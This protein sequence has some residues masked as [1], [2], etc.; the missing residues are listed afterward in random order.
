MAPIRF[1]FGLHLH[2]PVGNFDHV[3]QQHVHDVYRPILER[4][5]E[6]GFLP[7]VL[8]LSG[9]LLEWLEEHDTGY[10]DLLG[11]LVS[12]RKVELLLAGFYEPVLASLPRADRVEQIQWMRDAVRRRFGVEGRGLWLTER[13]WEPELAADL[14]DAGVRYALVD[15]RHFLVS[16]FGSEQLHAPYWTESDGKRVALFPIDERLRYLIPFRPPEETASYL[17]GLR[18]AGHRLA[19]LADDGEKFGGWPGTREWVYERGWLDRFTGTIGGLVQAGEVQLSTLSDA[20]DTVPSAGIAYLPTASYREMEGWSLPPDAALRLI[21]LERE[22]GE[23]RMAGPDGALI[24]GAHWRNF[25][26]K[27]SESNRMHK[28]MQALSLL[29][30]QRGDPPSARRAIGRAQCNDAYWHGVFGGLYLPHLRE[31]IWRNLA[32]AEAELRRGEAV[33]VE[34]LDLDGDGHDE[35]WIHSDQFSAWLSPRRGGALEE[36][37]VFATGINYANALTRRREAYHDTA[38][39]QEAEAHAAAEGGAPSIHDIEEG[40]RLEHRPYVDAEPRAIF[41]ERVLPGDLTIEQYVSGDYRAVRSWA[42]SPCSFTIDR[43]HDSATIVC[44]FGAEAPLEKR[45][46]FA[47][48]GSLAVAYRWDPSIG[49]PEDFF[50]PELSLFAPLEVR[51]EPVAEVWSFPIETVAKSERGL[52]RTRQGDSMTLRWP[53]RRGHATVQMSWRLEPAMTSASE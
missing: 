52:D 20:L 51:S 32:L 9:P 50:A 53:V 12:D 28:K 8:H 37:T 22:L 17:R 21:R 15:D 23:E 2:Q 41:L 4:L 34:V 26:V 19:V 44:S 24:R 13:V 1:V 30:R 3:F 6:R 16:G 10:L 43:Q 49:Q 27:Y 47:A 5:S 7:L 11:R 18:G 14:A 45:I 40:I 25:L 38:L 31:A 36:Y 39:E 33:G 35:I 48:D 46:E 42:Q 29:C